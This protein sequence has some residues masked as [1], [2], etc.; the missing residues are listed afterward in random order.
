MGIGGGGGGGG[1]GARVGWAGQTFLRLSFHFL[2]NIT[3]HKQC[4]FS[5]EHVWIYILEDIS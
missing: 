2:F 5:T 1:E 4:S 3:A